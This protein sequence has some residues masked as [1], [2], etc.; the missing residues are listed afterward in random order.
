LTVGPDQLI[1]WRSHHEIADAGR[2]PPPLSGRPR[3]RDR[4]KSGGVQREASNKWKERR[5]Q[6][7]VAVTS[8]QR[9]C[10]HYHAS[11]AERAFDQRWGSVVKSREN[12][13]VGSGRQAGIAEESWLAQNG[14]AAS[15]CLE[16][17]MFKRD[18]TEDSAPI[19]RA[20]SVGLP[21][22]W[23]QAHVGPR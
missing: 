4:D 20:V 11:V 5:M 22:R 13:G 19:R 15:E 18:I 9:E 12:G 17:R 7:E 2:R 10:D 21:G 16:D 23:K 6:R 8:V 3:E 14:A 1:G